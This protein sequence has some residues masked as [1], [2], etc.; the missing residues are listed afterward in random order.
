MDKLAMDIS[1]QGRKVSVEENA[2]DRLVRFVSPGRGLRRFQDRVRA[3][4]ISGGYNAGKRT[5]N[6]TRGWNHTG[7]DPDTDIIADLPTMRERSR[8]HRRN[9]PLAAGAINTNVTNVVGP[10]LEMR[11]C[12]DYELLGMTEDEADAWET[13]TERW[14]GVWSG[15]PSEC[16]AARM[17][18]LNGIMGLTYNQTLEN[19]DVLVSKP[20]KERPGCYFGLKL[21]VIEADRISNPNNQADKDGMAGG[22]EYDP[23]SGEPLKYHVSKFHPGAIKVSKREW[24]EIKAFSDDGRRSAYHLYFMLR[25]NQ[26]RGVPYLAPVIEPLKQL[27]NFTESE[28]QAAV[29]QSVFTTFVYSEEGDAE[30]FVTPSENSTATSSEDSIGL[31]SGNIVGV[32]NG[33][34]VEFANPS[35]PNTAFDPFFLAIVRQIGVALEI[36]YE[37]LIKHFTASYSAARAALQEAWKYFIFRRKWLVDNFCQPVYCDWMDEAVARD[38][39]QAPGYFDDPL[40]RRAYQGAI[41]IGPAKGMINEQAEVSAAKERIDAG[42]SYREYESATLLGLDSS[43]VHKKLAREEAKRRKDGLGATQQPAGP[44]RPAAPVPQQ[45][46]PK[47]DKKEDEEETEK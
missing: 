41:W 10:G 44:G 12:I 30:L 35:R 34:K 39:I 6:A 7:G 5:R 38:Y 26:H 36:P 4:A 21:Q 17:L 16:D 33:Q 3:A 42:L 23:E 9:N 47:D 32:K 45:P 15:N 14:Y 19:G 43:I 29:L 18:T 24:M 20:W 1:L 2:V 27:G 13:N 31:G 8:D 37:I 46:N 22:V 40:I 11:A 25:P 28:L